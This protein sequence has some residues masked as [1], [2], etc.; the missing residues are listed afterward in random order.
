MITDINLFLFFRL[1]MPFHFPQADA[2]QKSNI[3]CPITDGQ[4]YG[5]SVQLPVL[6]SYP[7]IK[8]IV[9]WQL[10]DESGN[11]VVCVEIPSRLEAM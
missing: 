3:S 7:R 1:P 4:A 2:C 10:K 11:D 8:V 5:Y 6:K 9:K